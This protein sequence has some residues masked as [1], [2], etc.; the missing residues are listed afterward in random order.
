MNNQQ[1]LNS[2]IHSKYF[3]LST[4]EFIKL[5]DKKTLELKSINNTNINIEYLNRLSASCV[6]LL[7]D[8]DKMESNYDMGR[9]VKKLYKTISQNLGK[10]H[11]ERNN[12]IFKLVDENNRKLTVI[13]GIDVGLVIDYFTQEELNNLWGYFD[14]MCLSSISIISDTNPSRKQGKVWNL[15]TTLKQ[16]VNESGI[17][18]TE[19]FYNPYINYNIETEEFSVSSLYDNVEQLEKHDG[20]LP[21]ETIIKLLGLEKFINSMLKELEDLNPEELKKSIS[22]ITKILKLDSDNE[23]S[24]VCNL[25]VNGVIE[26]LKTKSAEGKP[27]NVILTEIIQS[28]TERA[29]TMD[30]ETMKKAVDNISQMKNLGEDE[31]KKMTDQNGNPIGTHVMSKMTKAFKMMNDINEGKQINIFEIKNEL[32]DLIKNLKQE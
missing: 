4:Q 12:N 15:L 21:L 18:M 16:K 24:N 14:I 6:Q 3:N 26:D 17:L 2:L 27:L 9:L 31:I 25:L 28:G 32:T 13:S 8:L 22:D 11:P 10:I 23:T 20:N 5:V 7:N 1:M 19:R 30:P 29:K